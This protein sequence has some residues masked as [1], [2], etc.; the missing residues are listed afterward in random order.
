MLG[1]D[2]HAD[3]QMDKYGFQAEEKAVIVGVANPDK[4]RQLIKNARRKLLIDVPGYGT[5][6]AVPIKSVGGG[7]TLAYL[8]NNSQTEHIDKKT[9]K[10]KFAY[11]LILVVLNQ[12]Y[13]D[14][15][16]QVA[17]AA[18]ASGGT[19]LH[20]K[21]TSKEAQKF[22][23]VSLANEKEVIM[24]VAK[25]ADKARIMQAII[26]HHRP[27]NPG[28]RDHLFAADRGGPPAS[29]TWSS[30]RARQSPA[31]PLTG[32]QGAGAGCTLRPA[33]ALLWCQPGRVSHSGKHGLFYFPR[34]RT[35]RAA[36]RRRPLQASSPRST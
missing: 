33:A 36:G 9:P 26:E 35:P 20:A 19:V 1:S 31:R 12:S 21:G 27:G 4:T 10:F 14:D 30:S 23:G 3:E 28:R 32:G 8:T 29:A 7:K 25:A 17:R 15:V 6:M 2:P 13:M 18:G 34:P 11:E 5:I 16:M 22:F 24:I